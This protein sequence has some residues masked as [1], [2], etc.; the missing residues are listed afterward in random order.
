[1]DKQAIALFI[2]IFA[3]MIPIVA[4]IGS[5]VL[6]IQKAKLEEARLHA[7]DPGMVAEVEELRQELQQVR[8]E[9]AEMQERLDFTERMLTS[10]SG[11]PKENA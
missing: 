9:V 7:G 11:G 2:P 5:M 1:M 4:I 10:R 8:G 3:L 6:K